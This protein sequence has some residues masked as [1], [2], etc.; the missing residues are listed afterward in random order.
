M[1]G[2]REILPQRIK[3][4]KRSA[5]RSLMLLVP[6]VFVGGCSGLIS[7]NSQQAPPP[8]TY[9][10][11]G[12]IS[13][14]AGGNG[15]TVTLSGAG[16][17]TTTADSS[18]AF[19]FKGLANG[20]Y[21]LTPSRTGYTFS[22]TSQNVTVNGATVAGVS[23]TAT[24]QVNP[25]YSVSGTISPAAGGNGA[26]V[27]LSGA[28]NASTTTNNSG[29][30]TFAGLSNGVYVITP[31]L[32]GYTY[33]PASQNATV[34]GANV[35]AVNFTASV[36]A[37]AP[38]ITAQPANQTVTAGQ[39]ATF[40][41][42]AAGTAP[43]SYQ[44]QKSGVSLAGA[45]ASSYTTP[46]TATTDNGSTFTVVVS[47]AAGSVT[48]NAALLT[49]SPASVAPSITSLNPTSGPVGS[50]VTITGANFGATQGTSTVRFNGT[51]AVPT[52]WSA[53]SIVATVPAGAT[54]GNVVVT[55]G[56]TA[57]NGVNF[58]VTVP[59][60]SITSLNPAAG[61]VGTSVTI[62]G[63]NF[64]ATQGSSTVK[65]NGIS[66]V[67]TSW[68][69][70]SIATTVPAGATTGNVV[71]T[72]GGVTSNGASFTVTVPPPPSITSLNPT[73]GVAGTPVTISGANFA[74]SQGS[75]TVTFNGIG[76]VPTSWSATSI[77]V[78]VPAGATTGNVVVTVGGVASNGAS[79]TVTS[80]GPSITNLNPS[81]G[82]VGVPVTVSGAN[83]GA[84]QGTSTVKFNGTAATP[85]S[86]S[87]T[88]IVAPV[89][90][91]ATTGNVVVTVG[92]VASNGVGFTVTVA[93]PSITSLS[94][95]SGVI[96]TSVT[97]AG[98]N[99]GSTQ[100]TSMVKFSGVAAVPTSWSA[101]SIAVPVP[102]GATTGNVVVTVGGVASN[103]VSFTVTADT[104][105]PVVTITAPANNA[106]VSGTITLTATATDPDSPVSFVQFQLDGA[107]TGAQLTTAPYS[108]SLDTT[109]LSNATHSLA[110]VAQD[111]SGNVG[112]S[113]AVTITVSNTTNT[114][115]GPLKQSTSNPNYFVNPA[116]KT[117]VLAGTQTWNSAQDTDKSPAGSNP[118]QTLD[119][120]AYIANL[121][122]WGHSVTI[123]W[124]KDLPHYCAWGGGGG[125]WTMGPWPW[126]RSSTPGA[127]DGGNKFDLNTFN[128]AFFDRIRARALQAQKNGIYVIV[129]LFDGF[130]ISNNRCST[131]GF[132]LTGA[133]NI[134]GVDDGGVDNSMT[135]SAPNAIAAVQEAYVKKMVDTLNDLQNVLWEPSEEG[136][137]GMEGFWQPFMIDLLHKYEGGGTLT[138][139]GETFPGKPFKH[140]VLYAS[141]GNL[142]GDSLMNDSNADAVAP[143]AHISPTSSCGSGTPTCKVN[144][145][146]SD[147]SYGGIWNDSQLNQRIWIWDNITN[148][149]GVMLMDPYIIFSAGGRNSCASPILG[150][151]PAPITSAG[152]YQMNIRLNMGYA[153]RYLNGKMNLNSSKPQPSLCSTSQCLATNTATHFE[154]LVYSPNANAFTVNLSVQN[155][156]TMHV[157]WL[158]PVTGAI[159]NMA[160]YTATS[161]TA[162]SFTPPGTLT[163]DAVLYLVDVNG[164]PL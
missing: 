36:A 87:A 154:F 163:T 53:T 121:V 17:A 54:T 77:A 150:V 145:N 162:Q 129:E 131:D 22:P 86:W 3:S 73:S 70:T 104:T 124:H 59:A 102:A 103:G 64:G 122:A 40:V 10:L 19:T 113:A 6:L 78:P 30:Y 11:M 156:K 101:T 12:T 61:L 119:Y 32:T 16:S 114:S 38:T 137:T 20:T 47:N 117:I 88:S 110:A 57:S 91:G 41:V 81:S 27:T 142:A 136:P 79:F 31:S 5:L 63:A 67:P 25:T 28:A 164:G 123:L 35:T 95:T 44:W 80:P 141:P 128:Q 144:I 151:C 118:S 98:A 120:N 139:T 107:N 52:S 7:Q 149:N 125:D 37:V 66:A 94:P 99:F 58:T 72:V 76:A 108:L 148:G 74:T 126:M 146:D 18:G 21:A 134:N 33:A 75:S 130:G 157:Q 26:A 93:G 24:Q 56:G 51:S 49:V 152:S 85:A 138:Q 100:G 55:A 39:T 84:T 82:L 111:P 133:N 90:A 155:G 60:P 135:M 160:D 2:A 147:H 50:S 29:N 45:T 106:T 140:P 65:F 127:T 89:P 42:V 115:M 9:S 92:G 158:D 8:Q 68:S 143:S 97:I 161:S 109:T 159:T 71:V 1:S 48:S 105:A 132:P 15:A 62:S 69:A 43:L 96:G 14:A 34:N 23:F 83:F 116:G 153:V 46:A 112:T 4:T 13:P